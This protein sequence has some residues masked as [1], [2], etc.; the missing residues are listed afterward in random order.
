M[1][2]TSHSAA[3][4]CLWLALAYDANGQREA[5]LAL[6]RRLEDTHPARDV[7]KQAYDLRYI[8]EAPQLEIGAD[9]R[10]SI[11]PVLDGAQF[12]RVPPRAGV[13]MLARCEPR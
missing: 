7:R 2:T 12:K 10:V 9:E 1:L 13:G 8:L 5:C 11:P 4:T 6:Y 3:Q